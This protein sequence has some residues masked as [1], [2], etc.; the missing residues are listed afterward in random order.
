MGF[1]FG[2]T[3]RPMSLLGVEKGRF[4]ITMDFLGDVFRATAA[5]ASPRSNP[6]SDILYGLIGFVSTGLGLKLKHV[7]TDDTSSPPPRSDCP[8]GVGRSTRK[9]LRTGKNTASIV[10]IRATCPEAHYPRIMRGLM[11]NK[12]ICP[13]GTTVEQYTFRRPWDGGNLHNT[14]YYGCCIFYSVPL[15]LLMGASHERCVDPI[16]GTIA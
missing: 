16:G 3:N 5:C 4:H 14:H 7:R 6:L 1:C 10:A 8:S 15:G 11:I 2:Q 13:D 12:I 9:W